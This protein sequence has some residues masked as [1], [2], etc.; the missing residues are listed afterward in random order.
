MS[1]YA[2]SQ[3]ENWQADANKGGAAHEQSV[4]EI[5]TKYF[6]TEEG[7]NYVYEPH[8][9]LLD[10]LFLEVD[11]K[12]NP[13]KYAKGNEISYDEVKKRFVKASGGEARLGM[14]PDGLIW[15]KLTGKGHFLEEK[16]QNAMGNA[17]ERAYRYDTEKIRKLLQEK[18][19]VSGQPVS[20]IFT[21][22]MTESQKY[23]LEIAAHLPDDHYVL[24]TSTQNKETV[25]IDWFN[26]VVK[27]LL[28]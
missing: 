1:S 14:I 18:L 23:I 17:H 2:L 27:P 5:F 25:L 19:D 11:Y 22:S 28:E 8:P 20:W 10:Q 7:I 16:K 21:G 24:L 12:K 13:T 6:S 9:S 26:R 15:N 3:R 4:K